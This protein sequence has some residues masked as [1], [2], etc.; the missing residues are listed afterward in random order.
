MSINHQSPVALATL[1]GGSVLAPMLAVAACWK[2][3]AGWPCPSDPPVSNCYYQ[4][5]TDS[6]CYSPNQAGNGEHKINQTAQ[7]QWEWK[8]RD[9]EGDCTV[10]HPLYTENRSCYITNGATCSSSGEPGEN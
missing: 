10:T 3:D 7:C 8:T 5:V 1:V 9:T 6:I 2:N 4:L